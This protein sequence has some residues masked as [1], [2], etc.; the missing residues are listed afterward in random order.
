MSEPREPLRRIVVVGDGPLGTMAALALRRTLPTAQVVVIGLPPHPASFAERSPG[1]LP[2]SLW[3]LE[4]IGVSE[5]ELIQQCGGSHR[6][7][8]RYIVKDSEKVAA[9]GAEVDPRKHTGFARNWGSGPRNVSQPAAP[10]SLAEILAANGRFAPPPPGAQSPLANVEYTLRWHAGA[11]RDLLARKAQAI[12]VQRVEGAISALRPDGQ[13]GVAALAIADAG[14]IEADL[15][16]DC[17]GPRAVMLSALADARRIDWSVELPVAGVMFA[18][19]GQPMAVLEDR[20][21]MTD[22]GW[23]W[24]VPGRDGLAAILAVAAGA[25]RLRG[26]G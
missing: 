23:R 16:V 14:E 4:R 26:C 18:P 17:S 15:F 11:L 7:T 13:G 3:L 19:P 22:S 25:K 2:F 10:G 5:E 6:L 12:G 8:M 21:T 20:L 9:Y 24:D 1:A